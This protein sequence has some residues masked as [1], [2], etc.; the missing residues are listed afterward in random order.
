MFGPNT[1]AEKMRSPV[2]GAK[3]Q[4]RKGEKLNVCVCYLRGFSLYEMLTKHHVLPESVTKTSMMGKVEENNDT[5]AQKDERKVAAD[6][7]ATPKATDTEQKDVK[8]E[9]ADQAF[10]H[11]QSESPEEPADNQGA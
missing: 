8:E 7:G 10:T 9:T 2:T 1:P 4:K 5:K 11:D 6:T 3:T